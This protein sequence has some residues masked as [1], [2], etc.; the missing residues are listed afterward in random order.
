MEEDSTVLAGD[1]QAFDSL[2]RYCISHDLSSDE[3]Y[4]I[5]E[6]LLDISSMMDYFIVETFFNN[7]DWPYNNIKYW[8]PKI[9]GKWKYI[10]IDTDAALNAYT[11]SFHNVMEIRISMYLFCVHCCNIRK[12]GDILSIDMRIFS[13]AFVCLEYWK[14]H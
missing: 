5:V 2:Y 14:I 1:P 8:K 6:E 10:L 12:L 7:T 3:N 4:K 11:W 13:I 9:G